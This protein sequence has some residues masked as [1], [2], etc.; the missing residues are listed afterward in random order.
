MK[1]IIIAVLGLVLM[2]GCAVQ[3]K[4]NMSEKDKTPIE[5]STRPK[6]SG[7]YIISELD[8]EKLNVEEFKGINPIIYFNVDKKT[9]SANV[10]CNQ[11]NGGYVI[12]GNHMKINQ[13]MST[14]MA[15]PNDLEDKLLKALMEVNSF[16][17]DNFILRLKKDDKV[18]MV[19]QPL[20]R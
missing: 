8:G 3:E 2:I 17:V 11:I 1:K 9:Y 5:K 13:G 10:G 7:K 18:M 6:V 4:H 14:M 16:K 12:K 19:L 15:C 20:A